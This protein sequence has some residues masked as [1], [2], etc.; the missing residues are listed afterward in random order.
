M[1]PSIVAMTGW[2]NIWRRKVVTELLNVDQC[3]EELLSAVDTNTTV[4]TDL[5]REERKSP[6]ATSSDNP[7]PHKLSICRFV[8]PLSAKQYSDVDIAF[9]HEC[10]RLPGLTLLHI[11]QHP[12]LRYHILPLPVHDHQST[13]VMLLVAALPGAAPTTQ[14][15]SSDHTVSCWSV[16]KVITHQN[17]SISSSTNCSNILFLFNKLINSFYTI[18]KSW[19]VRSSLVRQA[20]KWILLWRRTVSSATSQPDHQKTQENKIELSRVET[21]HWSKTVE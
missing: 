13:A 6:A 11:V 10:S 8:N 2:A 9:L 15:Y 3:C 14:L 5:H 18:I 16:I 19:S 7:H 1:F 4:V 17:E 20:S 12:A 21:A